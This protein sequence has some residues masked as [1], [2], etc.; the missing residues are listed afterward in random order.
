MGL[1]AG[2]SSGCGEELGPEPMRTVTVSGS[3]RAGGRP[4]GRG[5]IEFVPVEGTVGNPRSAPLR[6]D[7]TFQATRVAVGRNVVGLADPP[8][9]L[10][11]GRL[12]ETFTSP[13]RREIPD[14]RV[15]WLT[16]DLV[17]EAIRHRDSRPTGPQGAR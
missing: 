5:W 12:F 14:R 9:G 10:P 4:V 2:S 8:G 17:E 15:T 7:G 16:I 6:P 13:I 3:V 1:L 11:G